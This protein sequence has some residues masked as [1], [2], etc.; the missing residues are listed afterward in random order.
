MGHFFSCKYKCA[1]T[2]RNQAKTN[3]GDA[4]SLHKDFSNH[5]VIKRQTGAQVLPVCR[6]FNKVPWVL[7]VALQGIYLRSNDYA[8]EVRTVS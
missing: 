1:R 8:L 2:P 4:N 5:R 7:V 3:S 6:G